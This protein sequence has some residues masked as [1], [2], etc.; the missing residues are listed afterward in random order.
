MAGAARGHRRKKLAQLH[1]DIA[2]PNLHTLG[3]IAGFD[4][5]EVQDIAMHR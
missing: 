1:G 2:L 3:G 4:A 5:F